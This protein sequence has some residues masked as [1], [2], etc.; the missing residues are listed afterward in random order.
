MKQ[1]LQISLF[2]IFASGVFYSAFAQIHDP[3]TNSSYQK[4]TRAVKK[5]GFSTK[6]YLPKTLEFNRD[7]FKAFPKINKRIEKTALDFIRD[8]GNY[9]EVFGRINNKIETANE[10]ESSYENHRKRSQQWGNPQFDGLNIKLIGVFSGK[11]FFAV[12]YL[13]EAKDNEFR[14]A[15]IFGERIFYKVNLNTK[16]ITRFQASPP[17]KQI[18]GLKQ[19]IRKKL[20]RLYLIA[21]EKVKV[22]DAKKPSDFLETDLNINL[23]KV[24]YSDAKIYPFTFGVL[25]EFEAFTESSKLF[26]GKAFRL[27]IPY[28]ERAPFINTFPKLSPF[29]SSKI[30]WPSA[31][32]LSKLEQEHWGARQLNLSARHP[33]IP[34]K[35]RKKEGV[36]SLERL[37]IQLYENG[38]ST[39]VNTSL[40]FYNPE[41]QITRSET[42]NPDGDVTYGQRFSYAEGNLQSKLTLG[43]TKALTLISYYKD[44]LESKTTISQSHQEFPGRDYGGIEIG[45]SH[46]FYNGMTR[47][48]FTMQNIG[49]SVLEV[50]KH[51]RQVYGSNYNK[52]LESNG[53]LRNENG[54]IIEAHSP[55]GRDHFYAEYDGQNR[56]HSFKRYEGTYLK[57]EID[58]TYFKNTS[59]PKKVHS[60]QRNTEKEYVYKWGFR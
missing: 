22:F 18:T 58:F 8:E 59:L 57:E 41:G 60:K 49:E 54:N 5:E 35:I 16:S 13:F 19:L 50:R 26:D 46:Y 36:K 43:R 29:F 11:A 38:D 9:L 31:E 45:Q 15:K 20:N 2:L 6:S 27:F 42:Q 40:S 21:T 1:E 52:A 44:G 10:I 56:F 7:Y 55:D 30:D 25:I 37:N 12:H 51:Y 23:K 34:V 3:F 17:E 14:K 53:I 32:N 39:L 28:S 48:F 47:F 4:S 24:N 33:E